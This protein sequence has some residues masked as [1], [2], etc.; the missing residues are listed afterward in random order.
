MSLYSSF[1]HCIRIGLFDQKNTTKAIICDFRDW[2]IKVSVAFAACQ[3]T[4]HV[5]TQTAL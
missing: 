5:D 1:L 2:A 4:C 3:M